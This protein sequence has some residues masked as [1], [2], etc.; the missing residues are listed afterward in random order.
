MILLFG[1]QYWLPLRAS[2]ITGGTYYALG[3]GGTFLGNLFRPGWLRPYLPHACI[4]C[5]GAFA[6]SL[7][8]LLADC[9]LNFVT[10]EWHQCVTNAFN[11]FV[12]ACSESVVC[13]GLAVACGYLCFGWLEM[14]REK[15]DDSPTPTPS[16]RKAVP[17]YKRCDLSYY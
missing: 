14:G 16:K 13:R 15:S 6:P 5:F 11:A 17:R 4:V 12:E 1:G 8:A 3:Y 2:G 10:W 7:I 9:K